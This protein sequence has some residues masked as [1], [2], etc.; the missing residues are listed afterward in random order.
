MR[1]LTEQQV[2][3]RLRRMLEGS[4]QAVV[5]RELKVSRQVVNQVVS[6]R[7]LSEKVLAGMNLE[8]CDNLY[9]RKAD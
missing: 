1:F 3:E 2:R 6:G 9:R 8:R 5:A 7:R 4:T